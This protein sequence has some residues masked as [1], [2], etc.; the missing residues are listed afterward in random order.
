MIAVKEQRKQGNSICISNSK[1]R[2]TA[3]WQ[4]WRVVDIWSRILEKSGESEML[5]K[6]NCPKR[7]EWIRHVSAGP[8]LGNSNRD[9][10]IRLI[11]HEVLLRPV[12]FVVIKLPVL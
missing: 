4:N 7:R 1:I 8:G 2:P 6:G 3:R 12:S 9:H 11:E 10:A 5:I